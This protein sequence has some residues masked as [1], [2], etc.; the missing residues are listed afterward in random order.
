MGYTYVNRRVSSRLRG[1]TH[2]HTSMTVY[3]CK[4]I[5]EIDW[6]LRL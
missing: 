3:P 2:T 4:N 5:D 6:H 1:C